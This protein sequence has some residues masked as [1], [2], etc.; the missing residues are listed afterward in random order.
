LI[1]AALV[2]DTP[3]VSR[4]VGP[5]LL[6]ALLVPACGKEIGDSC[7]TNVDCAQDGTRDCDLSQ[8][9]GYCTVNGCDEKSCP[10]EAVCIRVFPY[11]APGAACTQDAD[12]GSAGLCLPDGFCVPRASERRYCERKCGSNGDC[13]GGYVCREAGIEG[14][15]ANQSTY[16]SIALVANPDQSPAVKFCAP[17]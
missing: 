3:P 16:G 15:P 8:P 14:Q 7:N 6:L 13:R 17:Q 12:C 11:E 5:L 1:P 10:S 2:T 9:G 4:L